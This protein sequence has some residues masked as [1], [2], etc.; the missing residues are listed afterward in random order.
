[1]KTILFTPVSNR[2]TEKSFIDYQKTVVEYRANGFNPTWDTQKLSS[3]ITTAGKAVLCPD[4][5][6]LAFARKVDN[7]YN[8]ELC[9]VISIH[10][11]EHRNTDWKNNDTASERQVLGLE[12]DVLAFLAFTDIR[13]YLL[14]KN[15][16]NVSENYC[17]I[18][19]TVTFS[20]ADADLQALITAAA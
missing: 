13:P 12:R 14:R 18:A 8:C 7:D 1:M 19:G 15:G 2:D 6:Y 16:D 17:R 5:A 10:P 20:I 11:P 4:D 9:K 3:K